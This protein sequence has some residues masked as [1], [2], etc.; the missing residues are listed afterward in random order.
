[1][2]HY[3]RHDSRKDRYVLLGIGLAL[4]LNM[5]SELLGPKPYSKGN[6]FAT[7]YANELVV[8]TP[9]G[10]YLNM[11]VCKENTPIES[12]EIDVGEKDVKITQKPILKV[13][14][15]SCELSNRMFR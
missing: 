9:H 13:D 5:V 6:I 8:Y 1:M 10:N 3:E 11:L 12:Y 15:A 2:Q 14:A 7:R 4:T